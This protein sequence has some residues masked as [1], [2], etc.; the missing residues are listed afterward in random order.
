MDS[1]VT[2]ETNILLKVKNDIT[3]RI[4]VNRITSTIKDAKVFSPLKKIHEPIS[5]IFFPVPRPS[6]NYI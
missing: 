2:N 4:T 5:P 1:Y 6:I 3:N